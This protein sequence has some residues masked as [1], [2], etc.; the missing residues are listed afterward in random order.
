MIVFC[1]H[2]GRMNQ[3]DFESLEDIICSNCGNGEIMHNRNIIIECPSCGMG[4][5]KD[6][7]DWNGKC[8][9]CLTEIENPLHNKCWGRTVNKGQKFVKFSVNLQ[10]EELNWLKKRSKRENVQI[11]QILRLLIRKEGGLICKGKLLKEKEGA[12]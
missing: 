6:I 7:W 5:Q 11:G 10:P 4:Q 3:G 12:G 9:S 8:K 2:C 1:R